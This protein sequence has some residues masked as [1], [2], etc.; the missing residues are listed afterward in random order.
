MTEGPGPKV[1]ESQIAVHWREEE[2]LYPPQKF[3]D[4]ANAKDPAIYD[5]S[6]RTT[7]PTASPRTRTC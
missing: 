2:Y 4:Q 3:I 1:S 5:S 7:S 6:A